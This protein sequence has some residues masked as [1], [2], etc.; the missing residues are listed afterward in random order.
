MGAAQTFQS[1]KDRLKFCELSF[2]GC[3]KHR[4]DAG[5]SGVFSMTKATLCTANKDNQKCPLAW[6]L[7]PESGS[8]LKCLPLHPHT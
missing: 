5:R 4:E 1:P 6:H 3:A 7:G 8:I 2:L